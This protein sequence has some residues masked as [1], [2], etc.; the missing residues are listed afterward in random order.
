MSYFFFFLNF[1]LNGKQGYRKKALCCSPNPDAMKTLNCNADLCEDE[2]D[3]CANETGFID[4][5]TDGF[6]SVSKRSYKLSDGKV[7][8]SYNRPE[9]EARAKPNIK[10]GDPRTMTLYLNTLLRS[11]L[12]KDLELRT[13]AYPTGLN[14]LKGDGASTLPVQGGFA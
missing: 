14:V 4:S 7:M 9:I 10:P 13:R 8:W 2:E 5:S 12:F 3:E 11:S 6:S 1:K